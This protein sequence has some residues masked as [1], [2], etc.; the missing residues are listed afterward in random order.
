MKVV[1]AREMQ[2]IDRKAIEGFGIPGLVLMENAGLGGVGVIRESFSMISKMRVALFAGCGN[3][4]GDGLVI[5]RHLFN[6]GVDIQVFLLGKG[7]MVSDDCGVN[8]KIIRKM[9]IP[10]SEIV[11][12]VGLER[13]KPWIQAAELI[14]D[15]IF[16]TGLSREVSGVAVRVIEFINSLVAPVV[17]IDIPSGLSAD[18]GKPLGIAVRA[19]QTITFGL[20]KLGLILYPG[21]SFSGKVSLVDIGI[22]RRLLTDPS[23]RCNLLMEEEILPLLPLHPPDSHKGMCG[24]VVVL[25]GSIGMTGAAALASEA[26]LR[27]GAG[28]VTLGIPEGL[29]GIMEVKLTEVMTKPLPQTESGSLSLSGFKEILGILETADVLAI[30][31]GL[32]R[33]EE[34]CELIQQV[35]REVDLPMVI[36]A[37]AIYALS[38]DPQVLKREGSLTGILT[39]HPGEAARLLGLTTN[40]IQDDRIKAATRIA[41]EF[42]CISLLKGA[43]SIISDE[44]G[45]IYINPTGNVGMAS[46]GMG[47]VLT[48]MIAG[49][50]AQGLTCLDAAKL[51]VYLHGLAADLAIKE[52]DPACLVASDVISGISGALRS[53]KSSE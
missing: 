39:P 20:P 32:G 10:I 30:G 9:G 27:I 36:D 8:L 50:V 11:S 12:T 51:G 4:G 14:V 25:A 35:V 16:G 18:T 3:N 42:N 2:M 17:S 45:Q 33:N 53:L 46:G 40:K 5:A 7:S 26:A 29:N 15:A 38:L 52:K 43:R 13:A 44:E 24:R 37:D 41:R 34:T 48:G 23:I 47:D 21:A 28:L 49:L 1:S 19:S 31:P 22:P 6:Q